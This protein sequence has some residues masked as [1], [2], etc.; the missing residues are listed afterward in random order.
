MNLFHDLSSC[1]YVPISCVYEKFKKIAGGAYDILS[2]PCQKHVK[3]MSKYNA[4]SPSKSS[5]LRHIKYRN[6]L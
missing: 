6:Y 3:N 2:K 4:D 1:M 5:R